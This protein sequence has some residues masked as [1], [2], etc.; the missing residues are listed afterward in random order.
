MMT[1]SD[2]VLS[3]YYLPEQHH[4]IH[5]QYLLTICFTIVLYTILKQIVF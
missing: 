5:L 2:Q 4:E 1:H 3:V